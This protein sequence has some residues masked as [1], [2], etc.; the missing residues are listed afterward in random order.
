LLAVVEV[1]A[2]LTAQHFGNALK[3]IAR[4]FDGLGDRQKPYPG[5]VLG[6]AGASEPLWD[7]NGARVGEQIVGYLEVETDRCR[8]RRAAL[9]QGHQPNGFAYW[10]WRLLEE[11]YEGV[12]IGYRDA[13]L[14]E[15]YEDSDVQF[16]D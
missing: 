14:P 7:S 9:W 12:G 1:K 10:Y 2:T 15:G 13:P 5:F 4:A 8:I 6:F 16:D 11:L 3:Q